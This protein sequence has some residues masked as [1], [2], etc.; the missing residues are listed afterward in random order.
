MDALEEL[1][2]T[3]CARARWLRLTAAATGWSEAGAG[4]DCVGSMGAIPC[5]S[6]PMEGRDA[7]LWLPLLLCWLLLLIVLLLGLL[8][9][10]L[11][12][13]GLNPTGRWAAVA[14][15]LKELMLQQGG[16][17]SCSQSRV[18][19]SPA[20]AALAR[21]GSTTARLAPAKSAARNH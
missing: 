15:L 11:L 13:V 10:C 3:G 4:C 20:K 1:G 9:C 16:R 14:G 2:W 21:N 6:S 5:A 7:A 8:G 12:L 19:K 17:G 18:I